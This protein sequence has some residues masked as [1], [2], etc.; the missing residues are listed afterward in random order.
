MQPRD[1]GETD[2]SLPAAIE[3]DSQDGA[4]LDGELLRMDGGKGRGLRLA[5]AGGGAEE[6]CQDKQDEQARSRFNLLPSTID[7]YQSLPGFSFFPAEGAKFS[8]FPSSFFML[9]RS[10][11]ASSLVIFPSFRRSLSAPSCSVLASA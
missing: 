6:S 9:F 4:R 3:G 8:I 10:C 1:L 7:H 5:S 11:S 2:L